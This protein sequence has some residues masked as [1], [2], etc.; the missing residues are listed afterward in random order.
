[1][2]AYAAEFYK[3]GKLQ[4]AKIKAH[5]CYQ[6]GFLREEIQDH[7][8]EKLQLLIEQKTIKGTFE[9]GT[10]YTIIAAVL[11]LNK[12]IIRLIQ[13]FDFTRKNPKL[14]YIN[15]TES[16]ISLEDSILTAFLNLVGFDV[17]F[18]VP[19][20]YQSVEKFFNKRVMEEHQIGEYVYDL[21]VPDFGT[22]SSGIRR[23]WR[24]KIFKRGN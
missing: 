24:E 11:N 19:T 9:N 14:I 2:K 4:K 16:I 10:E 1:M 20:G 18:F 22:G 15:T 3:N 12:E 8:L 5:S 7:I 23:S 21:R 17:V 6:Y 13:K